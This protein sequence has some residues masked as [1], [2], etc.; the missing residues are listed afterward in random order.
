MAKNGKS[1]GNGKK[2]GK[3]NLRFTGWRR[4]NDR[5]GV[6]N[7]VV[8]L[9]LDRIVDLDISV[10]E[11]LKFVVSMGVVAPGPRLPSS[12]LVDAPIPAR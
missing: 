9:P 10:D 3:Y 8:I 1:N 6:R 12:A 7:H 4:E 11:A 2:N 5:V